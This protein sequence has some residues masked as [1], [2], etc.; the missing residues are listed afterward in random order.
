M[1]I[2]LRGHTLAHR[3][4][5]SR[6][7]PLFS[8]L[9]AA[10]SLSIPPTFA[11]TPITP[12]YTA[13]DL[14]TLG[15][16]YSIANAINDSGQVVGQAYTSGGFFHA[17]LFSGT[18]SGNIDLGTLGGG[19]AS[20][21]YGINNSGQIV[22]SAT[23][24]T[25]N[26]VTRATLFSGSGSGNIDLGNLG[27][28]SSYAFAAAYAISASGQIVGSSP[29]SYG[30]VDATIFSG[31]GSDNVDL[32]SG[33]AYAI[34]AAG[35]TVGYA[36]YAAMLFSENGGNGTDLGTLDGRVG[37][38]AYGI[39]ASGQI[40]G[41]APIAGGSPS[42]ATLFSGSG[43]DNIDLGTLGGSESVA[44]AINDFGQ[45]VG[46]SHISGDSRAH[47]FIYSGSAMTD[48]NDLVQPGSGITDIFIGGYGGAINNFGQIA[49]QGTVGSG[50]T[51]A[52]LLNPL[53]PL[54]T[55]SAGGTIRDTRFVGGMDYGKFTATTN[56]GNLD[57]TVSLLGGT[58]GSAGSGTFGLN[59]DVVVTMSTGDPDLLASDVV[60]LTGTEGDVIVLQLTYDEALASSLFGDEANSV[61]SWLDPSDGDWKNAVDGNSGGTP[62]F[63]AGAYD[64]MTDFH[65]G[66][67]G[68]DVA[69]NTVWAV[70]NHNSQFAVTAVPEPSSAGVAIGLGVLGLALTRRRTHRA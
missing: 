70:I 39:N 44:R 3:S 69:N 37:A 47:G 34:N 43:S 21:A 22:G 14:G 17:T 29:T 26:N 51:H 41:Y 66:Y 53:N 59:R 28:T 50:Q 35:Q 1:P 25:A 54:T 48:V 63:I 7:S 65:L 57:T 10:A 46:Y 6:F 13:V 52:V 12:A 38:V 8:L 45:I 67:Y 31:T 64:P 60:T 40:V 16:D 42:H 62:T 55:A 11:Q 61:L 27:Y 30:L 23:F 49:A 5:K 4:M 36:G 9:A 18:G 15:R 19:T 56:P 68:V 33:Y 2:F 24:T 58:T 32:G 20:E